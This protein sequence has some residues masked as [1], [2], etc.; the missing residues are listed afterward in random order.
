MHPMVFFVY[1]KGVVD[2]GMP[3]VPGMRRTWRRWSALQT[4]EK[5]LDVKKI[6][7]I[8][9]GLQASALPYGAK[10][11]LTDFMNNEE[12]YIHRL[13]ARRF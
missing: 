13:T 1:L 2:T 6:Q 12:L 11:G 9:V 5:L 10:C 4:S 3:A 7:G 8:A